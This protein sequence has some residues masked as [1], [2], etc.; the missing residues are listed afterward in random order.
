MTK[1]DFFWDTVYILQ[2]SEAF[3]QQGVTRTFYENL[4]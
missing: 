3:G 2:T 1:W 4:I